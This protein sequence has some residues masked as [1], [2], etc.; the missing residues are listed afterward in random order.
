MD[1]SAHQWKHIMAESEI[2]SLS[3]SSS[4]K[5][6]PSNQS[7]NEIFIHTLMYAVQLGPVLSVMN[8]FL[9]MLKLGLVWCPSH[10]MPF[11]DCSLLLGLVASSGM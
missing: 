8:S 10:P 7:N 2:Y 9:L 1:S 5:A 3:A 6:S 11:L 4:E